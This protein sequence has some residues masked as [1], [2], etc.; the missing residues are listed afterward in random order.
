VQKQWYYAAVVI[1][2]LCLSVSAHAGPSSPVELDFVE[3]GFATAYSQVTTGT[4]TQV[5]E[6]F[7]GYSLLVSVDDDNLYGPS[8]LGTDP[9]ISMSVQ[10]TN[11]GATPPANPVSIGM[12]ITGLT[13]Q[14]GTDITFDSSFTSIFH[15]TATANFQTNYDPTDTLFGQTEALSLANGLSSTSTSF[16]Q[17]LVGTVSSLYSMSM[18]VTFNPVAYA[19]PTLDGELEVESVPEPTSMALLG[20]GIA[21]LGVRIHR[22]NPPVPST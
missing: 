18:F 8:A 19:H 6:T 9:Y 11:V 4:T 12:S 21:G 17:T 2:S 16:D 7:G 20:V 13:A 5:N 10:V 15:S 1:G 14:P 22:M 3:S